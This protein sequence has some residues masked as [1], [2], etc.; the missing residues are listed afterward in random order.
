MK[1][2]KIIGSDAKWASKIIGKG[3][4]FFHSENFNY[5]FQKALKEKLVRD[6][7]ELQENFCL[8]VAEQ[9]KI[10][11][12]NGTIVVAKNHFKYMDM[13]DELAS[14]V[15]NSRLQ[16]IIS[17][18]AGSSR[19]LTVTLLDELI[20][21]KHLAKKES[22]LIFYD[23]SQLTDTELLLVQKH[24]DVHLYF[25]KNLP[26]LFKEGIAN[27]LAYGDMIEKPAIELIKENPCKTDKDLQVIFETD[28]EVFGSYSYFFTKYAKELLGQEKF[29]E[30][31]RSA[32]KME[33]PLEF[34]LTFED[35]LGVKQS[36][37]FDSNFLNYVGGL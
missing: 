35:M 12:A 16:L 6:F 24:E 25:S 29:F 27:L 13:L 18:S 31:M 34:K 28:S 5:F 37:D 10:A 19:A 7:I 21:A 4:N 14:N 36:K 9:F 11:P 26:E 3:F 20:N 23:K 30:L 15:G 22:K 32:E 33:S 8:D 2:P 1:N 17:L